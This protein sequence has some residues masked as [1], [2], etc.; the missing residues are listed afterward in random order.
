MGGD[1]EGSQQSTTQQVMSPEQ[2]KI[3]GMV[4]PIFQNYLK[5]G[6]AGLSGM[7]YPGA[8]VAP[9]SANETLANSMLKEQATGSLTN[10]ANS[11]LGGLD[12]LTSG[13]ALDPNTNPALRGTI[14]AAVRPLT[15][16]FSQAIMPEIRGDMILSGGYGSNRQG[17]ETA[18]AAQN[19]ER[20]IGDTSSAIAFQGY[21]AG[22]D[23]QSRALA[24][25][26]GVMQGAQLPGQTVSAIGTQERSF[27]QSLINDEMQRYY[28]QEFFPLMIAQQIAGT[29]FGYPGG[30]T[31]SMVSG[32][33][34][35]GGGGAAGA[36]GGAVGGAAIG[37]SLAGP[38]WGTAGG[39]ALGGL[40]GLFG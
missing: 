15:E 8:T 3:L 5:G 16:Q 17:I 30:S 26:P 32:A 38:G 40:L 23:A 19:L 2:K 24:F 6:N 31:Q 28:N 35:G 9:Q 18:N 25:A 27:D 37:T 34:G 11:A 10:S 7:V 21:N 1:D 13:R 12:F 4:T 29:M 39:A 20:Q 22:L 33:G 36:L 14:D